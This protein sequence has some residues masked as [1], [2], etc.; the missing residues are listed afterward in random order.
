MDFVTVSVTVLVAAGVS[1]YLRRKKRASLSVAAH[2]DENM[3]VSVE[4]PESSIADAPAPSPAEV[5]RPE[6]GSSDAPD[7]DSAEA[8]KNEADSKGVEVFIVDGECHWDDCAAWAKTLKIDSENEI[9]ILADYAKMGNLCGDIHEP[10]VKPCAV[11]V[12]L[13]SKEFNDLWQVK[14][15]QCDKL[16]GKIVE[17]LAADGMISLI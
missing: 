9:P 4:Q 17:A 5:E 13:Y 3:N 8:E 11:M 2:P 15:I 16:D 12:G 6:A 1:L 10:I 7:S 14:I